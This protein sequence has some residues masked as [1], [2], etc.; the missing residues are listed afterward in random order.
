MCRLWR[1]ALTSNSRFWQVLLQRLRSREALPA[2]PP[3]SQWNTGK[4]AANWRSVE[5][6][7]AFLLF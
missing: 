4:F 6:G 5:V 2:A 7:K 3:F 1:K